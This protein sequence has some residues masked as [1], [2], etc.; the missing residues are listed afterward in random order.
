MLKERTSPKQS[1]QSFVQGKK[2]KILSGSYTPL[3]D[4]N[5]I[6][7]FIHT[8][9][10]C[11]CSTLRFHVQRYTTRLFAIDLLSFYSGYIYL[12]MSSQKGSNQSRIMIR[13]MSQQSSQLKK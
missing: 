7:R 1:E 4:S 10:I 8:S 3:T 12:P 2:R 9:P 11:L 13:S 5:G 6:R